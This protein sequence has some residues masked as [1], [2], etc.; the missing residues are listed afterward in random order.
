M[1][2]KRLPLV[3]IISFMCMMMFI[4]IPCT[5][6][7]NIRPT[8]LTCEYMQNPR[9]VDVQFPR[10]SWINEVTIETV[11]GESQQAYRIVVASSEEN[12]QKSKFDVWDSG[13]IYSSNSYLVSYKGSKLLS[14]KDYWWKVMVWD[15]KGNASSCLLL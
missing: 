4:S 12:M 8:T 1:R 10:L 15:S 14:S 6:N 2:N 9:V 7:S 5:G 13:K 11:R 3:T